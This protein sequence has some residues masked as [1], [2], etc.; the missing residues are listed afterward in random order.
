MRYRIELSNRAARDLDR[1]GRDVQ[2][3][4][5]KRMERLAQNSYEARV[6]APL[7]GYEGLRK[8]RVGGWRIIF[9]VDDDTR[10]L[11]VVTIE[12]RGQVDQRI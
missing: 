6:S 3:R 8:S 7:A 5:I 1:L 10:R 9:T 11:H 4:M 2:E 12:R